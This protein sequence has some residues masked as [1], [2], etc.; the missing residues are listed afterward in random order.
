MKR[1][2]KV[3]GMALV[4]NLVPSN[5]FSEVAFAKDCVRVANLEEKNR[6]KGEIKFEWFFTRSGVDW[7]TEVYQTVLL[8]PSCV[9]ERRFQEAIDVT[10]E[11]Q[12][13]CKKVKKSSANYAKWKS[14]RKYWSGLYGQSFAY[15][16][17]KWKKVKLP[18]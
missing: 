9:S 8:N 17:T 2:S 12:S 14:D 7:S 5:H 15:A 6:L 3:I 18:R 4:L 1:L 10:R 13:V 11:I 16:C